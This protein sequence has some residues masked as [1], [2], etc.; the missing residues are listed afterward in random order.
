MPLLESLQ[1]NIPVLLIGTNIASS[2]LAKT[3]GAL[4]E[5][6]AQLEII[7]PLTRFARRVARPDELS[8]TIAEAVNVLYFASTLFVLGSL[9]LLADADLLLPVFFV[10]GIAI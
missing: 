9:V 7:Q 8:A 10:L 4:H 5:T 2:L 1:N 3:G 6:P